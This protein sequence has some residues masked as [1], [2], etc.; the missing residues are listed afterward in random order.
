MGSGSSDSPWVLREAPVPTLLS[1]KEGRYILGLVSC[2]LVPRICSVLTAGAASPP[3]TWPCWAQAASEWHVDTWSKWK[4]PASLGSRESWSLEAGVYLPNTGWAITLV[5][6]V[7][8]SIWHAGQLLT[9]SVSQLL[10]D[11]QSS[12]QHIS[13][14]YS[15]S[16]KH[17]CTTKEAFWSTF[18]N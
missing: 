6:E 12:I 4:E 13:R 17:N 15:I 10:L 14:T 2:F 3:A 5:M 1:S 18:Y 11:P 7:V 16:N 8:H 9:L